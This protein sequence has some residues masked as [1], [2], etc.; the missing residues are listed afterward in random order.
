LIAKKGVR[1]EKVITT[2]LRT[3]QCPLEI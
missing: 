3:L 2:K 1:R